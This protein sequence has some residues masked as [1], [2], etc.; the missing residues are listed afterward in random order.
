ML[1]ESSR[2]QA[3]REQLS[4]LAAAYAPRQGSILG[5]GAAATTRVE[6]REPTVYDY[7]PFAQDPN[8]N[9]EEPWEEIPIEQ[10]PALRGIRTAQPHE[11]EE[12]WNDENMHPTQNKQSRDELIDH[13]LSLLTRSEKVEIARRAGTQDVIRNVPARRPYSPPLNGA[14]N[15]GS[16]DQHTRNAEV[17]SPA[18]RQ[19]SPPLYGAGKAHQDDEEEAPPARHSVLQQR[20]KSAQPVG[21]TYLPQGTL[22]GR[23][24]VQR[25]SIA[26]NLTRAP[27]RLNPIMEP[28]GGP[29]TTGPQHTNLLY[30][31]PLP[32]YETE[33]RD[34]VAA[35]A[36]T[37]PRFTA[38]SGTPEEEGQKARHF[39]GLVEMH[40]AVT[41]GVTNSQKILIAVTNM[42]GAASEWFFTTNDRHAELYGGQPLFNS[43]QRFKELFLQRFGQM[44]TANAMA[45]LG[46]VKL[47]RGETVAT[48]AQNLEN[49]FFS[50][51]LVDEQAKL[52][53]F[54]RA[55]EDPLKSQVR[56]CK[57]LTLNQAVQDAIHFDQ[58]MSIEE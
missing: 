52:Y 26:E 33:K 39:L 44:N 35:K 32:V 37:T 43:F 7:G 40:A 8:G 2:E 14:L 49:L 38:F 9:E 23:D 18:R 4:Y 47:K 13:L 56:G 53:Y 24:G 31:P 34:N 30:G 12:R 21:S 20:S 54:F 51:N 5:A 10:P 15:N 6:R 1:E 41:K 36:F 29:E 17:K 3:A 28:V 58:R 42:K 22:P 46:D 48:F 50:A 45:Q 55:I 25:H 11:I 27:T 16:L 19:Y 57:P